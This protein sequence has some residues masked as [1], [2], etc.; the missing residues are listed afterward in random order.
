MESFPPP[1]QHLA[2]LHYHDAK[3]KKK[4]KKNLK[5]HELTLSESQFLLKRKLKR[6]DRITLYIVLLF[7]VID[8][9]HFFAKE[10]G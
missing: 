5:K 9:L 10:S 4:K 8:E 6:L 2:V 3:K 1:Q 7:R